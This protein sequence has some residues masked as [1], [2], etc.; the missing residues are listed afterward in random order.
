MSAAEKWVTTTDA[1]VA[2]VNDE[3]VERV[4]VSGHLTD[5]PSISLPPGRSLCGAAENSTIAFLPSSDGIQ[6][7]ADNSVQS[8]HL[9][10]SPERRAIFNDTTAPLS[11]PG[12]TARRDR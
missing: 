3:S 5:A 7:S 1:L 10:A 2:A 6:L 12:Q 9:K 11:G 8:L 4:V